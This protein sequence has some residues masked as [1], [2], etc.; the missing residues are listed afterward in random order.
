MWVVLHSGSRGIGNQLARRHID[1][2]KGLMKRYFIELD[3][4]DLAYLVEGTPEFDAYIADMLWAQRYALANRE[5]DDGRR[6]RPGRRLRSVATSR[7]PCAR[8]TAT[9]TSPSW[10]TTTAGTCGSP[11]RERSG[12]TPAT[13]GV[14]PGSM[15]TRVLH[16]ARASATPRRTTRAP[17]EPAAACPAA[18][19]AAAR[20]RRAARGDGRQGL[21]RADAQPLLDEDPRAYKDIDQVME[22]QRDLVRDR[23]HARA[24]SS[25]TRAC[26]PL[27]SRTAAA[28]T[29]R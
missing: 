3:D 21:E 5:R 7:S 10:S 12:P 15:G 9:T 11:A 23:A 25:T 8:S 20:P 24:R 2:A 28:V 29:T 1:E 13:E 19:P 14:I 16:R 27:G 4:P 18:R 6:P 22:D 26:D 17:T